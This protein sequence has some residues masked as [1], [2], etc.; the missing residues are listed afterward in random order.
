MVSKL[1]EALGI[2]IAADE[3]AVKASARLSGTT[4]TDGSFDPNAAKQLAE[5]SLDFLAG[6]AMPTIFEY[7]FPPVLLAAW[8]LL[9]EKGGQ[10]KDESK[11]A[12]GIPRGHGKTTLIKLFILFCVL[13]TKKKFILV[14]CS[15]Q[16]HAENLLADVEDMLNELNIIKLFGDWKTGVELKRQDL[17]KFGYRGRSITIAAIGAEGSLR[18]LNI[19][20]D[21]PDVMLFEDVQTKECSESQPQSESLLRWMIGTAMKARSPKG[22]LTIFNGNMYPGPNSILK[23]LKT[24]PGWIKFISG[25]ILADGTALWPELRSLESLLSELDNDISLGHPEIFFAEVLNDTEVGTNSRTD[26][27]R[28]RPWPHQDEDQ[29]QGKFIVIDPAQGKDGGDLVSIG[30]VEVFD[31]IPGLRDVIEE[32]LSPGNTIRRALLMA[33]RTGTR[34]IAVEAT[35]Y[36]YTLLYWFTEIAAQL[37]LTGFHFVPIYATTTSKNT[38]IAV[39]LKAL[40]ANE[41][42]VHPKVKSLVISQIVNWNPLRRNNT[43]GIL[44]LLTFTTPVLEAYGPV[45]ATDTDVSVL[46]LNAAKVVENNTCF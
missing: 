8:Q 36:Q 21:R 40:T 7:L 22:C 1:E 33:L 18:G 3:A 15:T 28:I 12:L 6:L 2:D 42:D 23:K 14:I 43:D 11:I 32:N 35:A 27:S 30:Y 10:L 17:K 25:A 41:I 19:K 16:G 13:F 39:M 24:N 45:I 29:P 38:R 34:V 26:L 20:N 44:D 37:Q 9:C 31:G 46:D 5:V 4:V